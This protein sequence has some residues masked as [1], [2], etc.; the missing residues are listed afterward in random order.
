ME[1]IRFIVLF[2]DDKQVIEAGYNEVSLCEFQEFTV[3]TWENFGSS[4][5]FC[6]EK[7]KVKAE[8]ESEWYDAVIVQVVLDE[9]VN[10]E[11]TIKFIRDLISLKKK[12]IEGVLRLVP[13]VNC[14]QRNRFITLKNVTT[15]E[16]EADGVHSL[17]TKKKNT[18]ANGSNY[19]SPSSD[20]ELPAFNTALLPQSVR[21]PTPAQRNLTLASTPPTV[22]HI[23]PLTQTPKTCGTSS[24]QSN[25]SVSKSRTP[26]STATQNGRQHTYADADEDADID[27]ID[28]RAVERLQRSL[29]KSGVDTSSLNGLSILSMLSARQSC[30]AVHRI[31]RLERLVL[32]LLEGISASLCTSSAASTSTATTDFEPIDSWESYIRF[33]SSRQIQSSLEPHLRGCRCPTLAETVRRMLAKCLSPR[34]LCLVNWSGRGGMLERCRAEL[35]DCTL[36]GKQLGFEN[37]RK[38]FF[39]AVKDLF[40]ADP[41]TKKLV[42]QDYDIQQAIIDVL[43]HA[44]EREA[45]REKRR[46]QAEAA[47]AAIVSTAADFDSASPSTTSRKRKKNRQ[48]SATGKRKGE[49]RPQKRRKTAHVLQDSDEAENLPSEISDDCQSVDSVELD[50]EN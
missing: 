18:Q 2:V 17:S 23:V 11:P 26:M 42:H 36:T 38:L 21:L 14:G 32:P 31:R 41:I 45:A 34:M 20:I 24:Q 44:T 29:A 47:T 19:A 6:D 50:S 28:P 8:Y 30:D 43:R 22:G 25:Q 49:G 9:A 10:T 3:E 1:S 12:S 33:I 16:S 7:L 37:A 15:S 46:I 39:D 4:Q 40:P 5:R 27:C 13:R 48:N 35:P